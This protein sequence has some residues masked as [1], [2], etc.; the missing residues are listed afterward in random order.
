MEGRGVQSPQQPVEREARPEERPIKSSANVA[1]VLVERDGVEKIAGDS[2]PRCELRILRD[3]RHV[4]VKKRG[5][6]DLPVKKQ[7]PA[8][9]EEN[10][11]GGRSPHVVMISDGILRQVEHSV[12]IRCKYGQEA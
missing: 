12:R 2:A 6:D 11:E 1:V 9:A 3:L 10:K 8:G 5:A 7:N 4:V